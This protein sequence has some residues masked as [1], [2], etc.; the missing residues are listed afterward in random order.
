MALEDNK[1][2]HLVELGGSNY[3]IVDGE[4]NIK[5]WDVKNELGELIGEVDELLFDPQ[6][7]QVRYLVV[8]LDQKL[9]LDDDKKVLVPIG[10][11]E[12]YKDG[13]A[14]DQ[15]DN[16]D[17]ENVV[18]DYTGSNLNPDY[19]IEG[20]YD[21]SSDGKVVVLPVSIEQLA[22][23]PSYQ[24]GNITPETESTV[25]N[26]F[27]GLGAAGLAEVLS[28]YNRD[29]FYVHD[30]FNENNFY[31]RKKLSGSEEKLEIG[32]QEVQTSGAYITS[33][34]VKDPLEESINLN[35]EHV[36]VEHTPVNSSVD[37]SDPGVFQEQYLD[38]PEHAKGPV[39][40]KEARVIEDIYI[41]KDLDDKEETIRETVRNTKVEA[42]RI[43]PDNE[44]RS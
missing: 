4:P 18:E 1:H 7:R 17:T 13:H 29:D 22:L 33:R 35:E 23:L 19:E 28:S 44:K 3:E 38:I 12:L 34:T 11:A 27:S 21:P 14:Q 20:V 42:E 43:D 2:D 30:H 32:N 31:D 8:E 9:G 24:K 5:G 40:D 10:I 16:I 37:S 15:E 25:R 26:I 6:S 36:N 41:T 39:I